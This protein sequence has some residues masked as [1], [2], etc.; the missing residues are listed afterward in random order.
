MPEPAPT[1]AT[2]PVRQVSIDTGRPYDA[3]RSDYE[4]AVP[5]FDRLE[6]IGVLRSG[7]GWEAIRALSAATA[8]HGFV[9][10]FVFDPSPVMKLNGSTGR[11]VTYLTSNIVVAEPAFRID[12][13]I[14][15]YF[16]LR[17]VIAE[18]TTGS[19]V[20]GFDVPV[21]LLAVHADPE[22]HR[23]ALAFG[24]SF[25][26]LLAYLGVEAPA[27]LTDPERGIGSMAASR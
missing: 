27:D 22:L 3:F 24:Q 1:I 6:A 26:G 11:A 19:A 12:P 21:D 5:P 17:V 10:F 16:P 4:A 23:F 14:I 15:L 13:A 7:G 2:R 18:S 9:N 8:V 25:A 20:L